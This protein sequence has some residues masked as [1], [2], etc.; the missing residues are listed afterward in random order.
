MKGKYISTSLL[1][2]VMASEKSAHMMHL[3]ETKAS[4][5]D[6]ELIWSKENPSVKQLKAR[7]QGRDELKL[8]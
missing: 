5:K 6:H 2:A 8:A 4:T 1:L 7:L 3:A